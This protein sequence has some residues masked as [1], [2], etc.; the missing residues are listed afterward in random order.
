MW[1]LSQLNFSLAKIIDL[2]S[3]VEVY[4][5]NLKDDILR[6]KQICDFPVVCGSAKSGSMQKLV[7]LLKEIVDS[8]RQNKE[9]E[10]LSA[11][12]APQAEMPELLL[13]HDSDLDDMLQEVLHE[14]TSY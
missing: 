12:L 1:K 9:A 13:T 11:L 6:L 5:R 10:Q 7:S 2:Q 8:I 3:D 4:Q 14:K